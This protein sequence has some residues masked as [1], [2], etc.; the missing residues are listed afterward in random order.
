MR[1]L[2]SYLIIIVYLFYLS[3]AWD[4]L[5]SRDAMKIDKSNNG[6]RCNDFV[7]RLKLNL[8]FFNFTQDLLVN[9]VYLLKYKT[10]VCYFDQ[11]EYRNLSIV[12]PNLN[13]SLNLV[14][15]AYYS[16]KFQ[17][18]MVNISENEIIVNSTVYS[19]ETEFIK[20]DHCDHYELN[21]D[22]NLELSINLVRKSPGG[23]VVYFYAGIMIL[24]CLV[25][26]SRFAGF[27][28][29]KYQRLP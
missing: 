27:F 28:Y 16:Y 14:L 26:A 20:F 29:S 22:S 10:S 21:I 25:V 7:D 2:E 17:L 18:K 4:N 19:N 9:R 6:F 8:N 1:I 12:Y 3:N 5:K 13:T 24:V 23:I 11:C 15:D